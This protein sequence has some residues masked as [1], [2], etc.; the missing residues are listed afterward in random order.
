MR[1]LIITLISV[2][3]KW[4]RFAVAML[5]LAG[6]CTIWLSCGQKDYTVRPVGPPP[7]F[8]QWSDGTKPPFSG[9]DSVKFKGELITPVP[10]LLT[11]DSV[12]EFLPMVVRNAPDD[13]V[14][15]VAMLSEGDEIPLGEFPA[16]GSSLQAGQ[17]SDIPSLL[18]HIIR[19]DL[20]KYEGKTVQFKWWLSA[21]TV[22]EYAEVAMFKV[23]KKRVKSDR[24]HILMICSDTHRYDFS[25]AGE[26]SELMPR[27]TEFRKDAVTYHRAYSDA[28]WTLPSIASTMTGRFPKFHVSGRRSATEPI[29]P[30]EA[31]IKPIPGSFSLAWAGVVRYFTLFPS[32][33]LEPFTSALRSDGY[34]TSWIVG[35]MFYT[36][37]GMGRHGL[38]LAFDMRSISGDK[39]NV[40]AKKLIA[41]IPDDRPV[42]MLVHYLDVHQYRIWKYN[43]KYPGENP[44]TGDRE[45]L[46]GCY[47]DAVRESD[48]YLG[49]LL[50]A[51]QEKYGFDNTLVVFYSDHGEHLR[52][53]GYGTYEELV[54]DRGESLEQFDL[55]VPLTDHG[56]SM[57]EVL[58]HI[59]LV[60]RYPKSMEMRGENH[61]AVALVDLYPTIM[62]VVGLPTP[63]GVELDGESL[64]KIARNDGKRSS[65]IHADYQL[66]GHEMSSIRDGALK[67]VVK[68]DEADIVVDQYLVNT[69]LP[70]TDKG[71][72]GQRIENSDLLEKLAKMYR[73]YSRVA[74][75]QSRGLK[76]NEIIDHRENAEDLADMGYLQVQKK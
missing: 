71:E 32:S 47:R 74:E 44:L 54:K 65:P 42:F 9:I 14:M 45:K 52:D 46:V 39:I 20:G 10:I 69:D 3:A 70:F 63:S 24:P 37:S 6:C 19:I 50:D 66:Y 76:S 36:L 67:Y 4:S 72:R 11:Q 41:D 23:Y 17:P 29:P 26:G 35:N 15:S 58:L 49:E 51:W 33:G 13:S 43:N 64:L 1:N 73:D 7:L 59:P 55:D 57:D 40:V 2:G 8:R 34:F 30:D 22:S 28:T 48:H 60:I 25:L 61:D 16:Y 21:G 68:M 12:L 27:L 62:D 38:E 75:E 53:P 5:A 31:D 56:N 18:D